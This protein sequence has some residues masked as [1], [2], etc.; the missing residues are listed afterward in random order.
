MHIAIIGCGF[1]ADYYLTT[2]RN[3]PSLALAGVF[4]ANPERLEAFSAFHKLKSYQS[5]EALLAD[6]DVAIVLNL[7]PPQ[8]HFE[9]SMA[10]LAAGK[11]VYSE[12]P[13]AMR[14]ED[15]ETLVRAADGRGLTLGAAPATVLG[16]AAKTAIAALKDGRIGTPRLVY[17]A[18]EDGPVFRDNWR[19]WR[20][21][22]GAPWP[23]AHEFEIGCAL[24]HA[25]Y[26][27]TW[28]CAMFGP[29]KTVH[30]FGARL[31]DDKGSGAPPEKL[32]TDYQSA[33]LVFES[34]VVAR[35]SC[36]LAAA[37]D[38]SMQIVGDKGSLFVEDGWNNRS[39]VRLV[40]ARKD[41]D[42][43]LAKLRRAGKRRLNALLPGLAP[44]G[45]RLQLAGRAA[46]T[47]TFPSRIDFM[48][49]VA[50]QAEA[51]RAGKRP[52][53]GGAFALHITELALIM[54]DA[55]PEGCSVLPR[56]RFAWPD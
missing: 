16:D 12:K 8:H 23:G 22:S 48:R 5:R 37:R 35:L 49:G 41:D 15:A 24:E 19:N 56:S 9:V 3:H 42:S 31:F 44:E 47:P 14:F 4:D 51:I 2:L 6:Q 21:T 43:L 20:S 53:T 46:L 45:E 13:L 11:H 50:A 32:A 10:I 55:G 17:A 52:S 54:Q 25:G 7:T 27:L 34:G 1:V 33:N 26:Y 38:R 28:L 40:A 30:A 39:P 29:V 36:G 18:M